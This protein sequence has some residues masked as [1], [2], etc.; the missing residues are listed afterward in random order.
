MLSLPTEIVL[1]LCEYLRQ[2]NLATFVFTEEE[3]ILVNREEG[4]KDWAAIGAKFDSNVE[5]R[6]DQR[7]EILETI[8][9]GRRKVVKFSVCTEAEHMAGKMRCR[10]AGKLG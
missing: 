9:T 10:T 1:D 7:E 2:R 3:C 5:D 4:G 6:V 8:R